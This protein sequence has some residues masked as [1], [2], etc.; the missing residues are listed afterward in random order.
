M[1]IAGTL[2]V[3]LVAGTVLCG[4]QSLSGSWQASADLDLGGGN[5][6]SLTTSLSVDYTIADWTFSS[7]S[8][9]GTGGWASQSF[10]AEG[11]LGDFS[12]SSSLDLDPSAVSF[13]KWLNAASWDFESVSLSATFEVTPNYVAS[14]FSAS[15]EAGDLSLS[16]DVDFRSQGTCDLLLNGADLSIG[17]P[18]CCT[19]VDVSLA[20][21]CDGFDEAA[22]SVSDIA[23]PGHS[24]I[25]LDADLE[26]MLDEK[27][28][29]LSP[30]FDFGDFACFDLYI[31]VNTS[32]NLSVGGISI[33]GI[34]LK[35][36]IGE[37]SFEAL[38]YVDGTHKLK[39]T[40]WEMYSVSFNDDGC[41]GPFSGNVVVYFLPGGLQ[42]FDVGLFEGTLALTLSEQVAFDM[43][44]TYDIEA[45]IFED[46]TLG[47]AVSW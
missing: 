45:G 32:G 21:S 17:F 4:G 46:L 23:I 3:L 9:F 13:K 41:C 36:D 40:Y 7:S 19:E 6:I 26:F 1:R 22:F 31:D 8:N 5:W 18:F 28:L 42:L 24:W 15:G 43:G 25:E 11:I 34:G 10:E 47:F 44:M 30:S 38:S 29:E 16:L 27:V 14:S 20:Y 2:A 35:C 33:Y 37:V 39:G 12:L